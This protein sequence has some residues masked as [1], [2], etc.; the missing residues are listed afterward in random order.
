M[1]INAALIGEHPAAATGA[2]RTAPI[3]LRAA[4]G[5]PPGDHHAGIDAQ[6][7]MAGVDLDILGPGIAGLRMLD[8]S[9]QCDPVGAGEG[10]RWEPVGP[11]PVR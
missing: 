7:A 4:S 5:D 6:P 9:R 10:S 1:V 3:R 2:A 11:D 8:R